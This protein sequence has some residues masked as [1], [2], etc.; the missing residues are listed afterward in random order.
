[1]VQQGH[2]AK[3]E[4]KSSNSVKNMVLSAMFLAIG[5]IL[6]FFTGQV[7]QIGNMLLPMHIPVLLCGLI[8]GWKYGLAVGII[9]PLLRSF[10]FPTPIL[11]PNAIAMAFELGTY[12]LVVGFWYQRS[13]WKCIVSLYRSMLLA[14]IC[15]RVV[16]GVVMIF[17]L[18]A[19]G[20]VF[21][22][23]AFLA[24]AFLNAI[25]GIVLQLLVI[26]A[27]MMALHKTRMVQFSKKSE[28][29]TISL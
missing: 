12:G 24:G 15:G 18:G 28:K 7:P 1:M 26:P 9:T 11:Y 10:L 2:E 20:N 13:K 16:W 17:L 22:L 14:M 21:T 19:K 27:I 3:S 6:P 29:R 8:C 5:I 23:E 25:P 4:N